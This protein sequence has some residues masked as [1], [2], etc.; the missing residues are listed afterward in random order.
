MSVRGVRSPTSAQEAALLEQ[1]A[2]ILKNT[3]N[4]PKNLNRLAKEEPFLV[5]VMIE[6]RKSEDGGVLSME[7]CRFSQGLL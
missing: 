2:P 7:A 1:G 6:E 5:L 3:A 4:R